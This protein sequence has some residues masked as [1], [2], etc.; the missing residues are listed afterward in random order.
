MSTPPGDSG[1]GYTLPDGR[2]AQARLKHVPPFVKDLPDA[3]GGLNI[4]THVPSFVTITCLCANPVV[5][6]NDDRQVTRLASVAKGARVLEVAASSEQRSNVAG[7]APMKK[8]YRPAVTKPTG[9]IFP[10]APG[11]G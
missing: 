8:V 11:A 5:G 3:V 10:N 4:I 1:N 2:G 6:S 9:R 7:G